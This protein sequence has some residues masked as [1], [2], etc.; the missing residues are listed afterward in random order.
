MTKRKTAGQNQVP[1]QNYSP[2]LL[3]DIAIKNF[4]PKVDTDGKPIRTEVRDNSNEDIA[5]YLLIQPSGHKSFAYRYEVK[6]K[7]RKFTL[8][9][10]RPPE[11]RKAGN[12]LSLARARVAAEDAKDKVDRGIDPAGEKKQAK[13]ERREAEANTLQAVAEDFLRRKAAMT[14]DPTGNVEFN[15]A[16]AKMRSGAL[17]HATLKRLVY[18]ALGNLPI[19]DIKRK[20]HITALLNKIEDKSGP[21]MATMVLAILRAIMNWHAAQDEDFTSPIVRG[22]AR[23]KTTERARSRVL[24]DDEI[25]DLWAALDTA[26]VPKCYPA[27]M[28]LL[29]YTA[30]RRTEAADMTSAE[31]RTENGRGDVWTIPAS[32][33]KTKR[34]HVVPLTRQAKAL[35]GGKPEGF[36][37]DGPW[38]IFSTTGGAKAFCGFSAAK[39]ALDAEIARI[40]KRDRRPPI[41]RW[42]THDLRRTGRSLMSRAKVDAD[43]AERAIGHVIGGVRGTYDRFDY[44]DQ[45]RE[46]FEKLAALVDVILNP[47]P[48][49]VARLDQRRKPKVRSAAG[50]VT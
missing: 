40:R 11:D 41:E 1:E 22:M 43:I 2:Q 24:D 37:G 21:A 14:T 5:L 23:I 18:P 6:G 29:L 45:K 26:D 35:I 48:D 32:R 10:W 49:N 46:A 39:R 50:A 3:T 8:G 13:E 42:T 44:F 12:H 47:H 31:I 9:T 7:S 25:R 15:P 17:W 34:D 30:T 20:T 38:F 36:E 16:K 27:Y 4:R 33:C 28:R 19:S